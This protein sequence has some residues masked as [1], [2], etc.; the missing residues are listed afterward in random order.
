MSDGSTADDGAEQQPEHS[1]TG[2]AFVDGDSSDD[3]V[4]AGRDDAA[5]FQMPVYAR[6]FATTSARAAKTDFGP[7]VPV[8]VLH[9]VRD[10][11]VG[12]WRFHGDDDHLGP[13]AEDL[14][15]ALDL[16]GDGEST[17]MVDA[18]DVG[19][20]ARQVLADR[21][22]ALESELAEKTLHVDDLEARAEALEAAGAQDSP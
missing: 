8:G 16:G 21:V 18:D 10:L 11:D 7:V 1:A 9:R 19:F 4:R 20:S 17:A 14:H 5:V 15:A 6:A 2:G 22:E 13:T 12:R 3:P